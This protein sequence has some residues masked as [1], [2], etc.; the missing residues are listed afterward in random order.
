MLLRARASVPSG[1][2][3]EVGRPMHQR[4]RRLNLYPPALRCA[5]RSAHRAMN[6]QRFIA[7]TSREPSDTQ[8]K[9]MPMES[10]KRGG[11][12]AATGEEAKMSREA[13]KK[14]SE[15]PAVS[16]PII[17]RSY[18]PVADL[19]ERLRPS[20]RYLASRRWTSERPGT[21]PSH[22]PRCGSSASRPSAAWGWVLG[23]ASGIS[24]EAQG[25]SREGCNE[26]PNQAKCR[27]SALLSAVP[28][29]HS[30]RSNPPW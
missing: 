2:T 23:T 11:A 29:S 8:G 27:E 19:E 3:S 26:Q 16:Y 4:S 30:S 13:H 9:L 18:E 14:A 24:G 15:K 20:S 28:T 22:A 6:G 12:E 25:P 7:V 5:I 21:S 17:L 1:Y 10:R